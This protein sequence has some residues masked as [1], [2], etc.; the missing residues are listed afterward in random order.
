MF[1]GTYKADPPFL[2]FFVRN[3]IEDNPVT[4]HLVAYPN[5][6]STSLITDLII[7]VTQIPANATL[8]RGNTDGHTWN[9]TS[10]DFG[11]VQLYLPEHAHGSFVMTVEAIDPV[12]EDF[13]P[14]SRQFTVTPV[15]DAPTLTVDCDPC[16]CSEIFNFR[17]NSSL[18]DT[19]GSEILRVMIAGLPE[20]VQLSAGQ[21]SSFGDY[22]LYLQDIS[23]VLTANFTG[24]NLNRLIMSIY[25]EAM[26]TSTGVKASNR[27]VVSIPQCSTITPTGIYN[28]YV[29]EDNCCVCM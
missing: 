28:S 27:T 8:S 22:T 19:D 10:S 11:E 13:T 17:I 4:I 12:A 26:E 16:L 7:R 3:G 2:E 29:H 21:K 18:V 24:V 14:L 9:L 25:A 23:N 1:A 5:S 15:P 6:D 20:G